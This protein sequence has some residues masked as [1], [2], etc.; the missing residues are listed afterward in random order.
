MGEQVL[1]VAIESSAAPGGSASS[2]TNADAPARPTS[3]TRGEGTSSQS[4]ESKSVLRPANRN[5]YAVVLG[6][7]GDLMGEAPPNVVPRSRTLLVSR[8]AEGMLRDA[9]AQQLGRPGVEVAQQASVR[10]WRAFVREH[11]RRK[12]DLIVIF[13][14]SKLSVQ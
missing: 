2:E 14:A 8:A 13:D 11:F 12:Y 4:V 9:D 6:R 5:G 10:E 7:I 1:E 3:L